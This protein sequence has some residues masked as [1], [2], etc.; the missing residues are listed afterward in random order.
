M[1]SH[2]WECHLHS[3]WEK[4]PT[5]NFVWYDDFDDNIQISNMNAHIHFHLVCGRNRKLDLFFFYQNDTRGF[6]PGCEPSSDL[7]LNYILKVMRFPAIH[8]ST[9]FLYQTHFFLS[10]GR[11]K[12][13]KVHTSRSMKTDWFKKRVKGSKSVNCATSAYKLSPWY[14]FVCFCKTFSKDGKGS[15]TSK[16]AAIQRELRKS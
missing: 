15:K 7:L 8:I 2:Q 6:L 4:L 1:W 13:Y 3:G 14:S 9:F 16:K 10:K 5:M 11:R 12:R